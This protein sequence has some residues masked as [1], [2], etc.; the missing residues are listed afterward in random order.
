MCMCYTHVHRY[1]HGHPYK[2]T[3]TRIHPHTYVYAHILSHTHAYTYAHIHRPTH[4]YTHTNM[5]NLCKRNHIG[6]RYICAHIHKHICNRYKQTQAY[7]HSGAY[8][9]MYTGA[10]IYINKY[11]RVQAFILTQAHPHIQADID[12]QYMHVHI[13]ICTRGCNNTIM[14]IHGQT[15]SHQW[16]SLG[17]GG[18]CAILLTY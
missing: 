2:S 16:Q 17:I 3:G 12:I 8:T 18:V 10:H 15:H 1:L 6:P 14:L 13:H 4:V 9:C 5:E 7:R 11:T